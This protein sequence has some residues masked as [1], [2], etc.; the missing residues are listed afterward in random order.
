VQHTRT[1]YQPK[2]EAVR[3]VVAIAIGFIVGVLA[4][5]IAPWEAAV[6]IGWDATVV[7]L[8]IW[9][10]SQV[11]RLDAVQTRAVAV[12]EDDSR[13]ATRVLLIASSVLSL[14]GVGLALY[15]SRHGTGDSW[16]IATFGVGTVMASWALVHTLFMLRYAHLY[17]SDEPGGI[18]FSPAHEAPDY[19][20]FA[21]FAFTVGMTFQVSDTAVESRSI[22]HTVLRHALLSY[23]FGVVIV[24]MTIN[25]IATLIP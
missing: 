16:I 4:A 12:H 15:N 23:I 1:R 20:D 17:Y 11:A 24:A 25:V 3:L 2:S 10:W 14:I 22:R 18:G 5:L 7:V 6:L 19:A 8:L 9:V 21:Y 13:N